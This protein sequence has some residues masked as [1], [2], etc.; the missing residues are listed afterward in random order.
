MHGHIAGLS[1]K[2]RSPH[3]GELDM[4]LA[5]LRTVHV[6]MGGGE[7]EFTIDAGTHGSDPGQWL[8]TGV[9]VDANFRIRITANGQVDLWPS[10]PGQYLTTPKGYTTA[11]KGS[12][13][14]AGAVVGRIGEAGAAFLIGESF[15]GAPAAD[16]RLYLQIVPSPWNNAST[17]SY[18]VRI[19]QK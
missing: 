5:E 13:F 16:G 7:V 2:G 15:D 17:G 12:K 11:G 4:K 1:I 14:M 9:N 18:R 10:G 6:G 8:D 3:F 19:V